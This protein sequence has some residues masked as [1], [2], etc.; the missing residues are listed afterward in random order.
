[1]IR[2]GAENENKKQVMEEQYAQHGE[3]EERNVAEEASIWAGYKLSVIRG[4][5]PHSNL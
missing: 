4:R 1:M 2:T 3:G 5:F